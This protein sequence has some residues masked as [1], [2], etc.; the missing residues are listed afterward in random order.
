MSRTP[1]RFKPLKNRR[2]F[3][4][5]SDEIKALIINGELKAGDR[6]PPEG[7]I[8]RQFQV[9]RQSVRD[10][11]RVLEQSGF[12]V[13]E[14]GG[15]GGPVIKDTIL[16]NL[17]SL[18]LDALK[19]KRTSLQ[20]FTIAR[21]DIEKLVFEHAARNMDESDI[22]SL[23][24]NV[25]EARQKV[26]KGLVAFDENMRF[27]ILLGRATKNYLFTI[28]TEVVRT[29]HADYFTNIQGEDLL[30]KSRQ[31]VGA[32]E[33]ILN[34]LIKGEVEKAR[35]LFGEHLGIV[36]STYYK[37]MDTTMPGEQLVSRKG[38]RLTHFKEG[39]HSDR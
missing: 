15:M 25:R 22:H 27:H 20:E 8:A 19:L 32:H 39:N 11:M 4:D 9:G 30:A 26:D 34:A 13:L 28:V 3:E 10:A 7:E 35:V 5:I 1:D 17:S 14:R 21:V 36:A 18:F 24:E 16:N 12:I 31:T 38:K 23:Q 29:I 33:A 37:S 2:T 6:L